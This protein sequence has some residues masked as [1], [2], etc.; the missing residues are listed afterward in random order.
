MLREIFLWFEDLV[1]IKE[2]VKKELEIICYF[3]KY[4]DRLVLFEDVEGWKVVGNIWSIWKRIVIYFNI[5]REEFIY[6]IV[7][8]MENLR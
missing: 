7:E 1:V 3:L 6:L 4:F 2:F 5:M 8:V